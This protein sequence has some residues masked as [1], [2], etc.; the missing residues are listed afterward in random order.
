MKFASKENGNIL[1]GFP[2]LLLV[3]MEYILGMLGGCG[4]ATSGEQCGGEHLA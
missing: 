3:M 1:E 4:M 2:Q